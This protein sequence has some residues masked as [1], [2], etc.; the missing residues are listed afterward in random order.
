[1]S[2]TQTLK[3]RYEKL[4]GLRKAHLNRARQCSKLTIPHLLPDE[5]HD[6]NRELPTPYQGFGAK[7]VNNLSSKLW[8]TMLPPGS[9]F[10]KLSLSLEVKQEIEQQ[11]GDEYSEANIMSGLAT[12]EEAVMD[13]IENRGVRTP[14]FTALRQLVVTGNVCVYVPKKTESHHPWSFHGYGLKVFTLDQYVVVRDSM[15]N[16]V[17]LVI[18]E[19]ISYAA[20][21]ED[22]KNTLSDEV[23]KDK[24]E[25]DTVQLY[26]RVLRKDDDSSKFTVTQEVEDTPLEGM[27]GE[28]D[29]DKLPWIVLRWSQDSDYGRGPVEEYLGDLS[30]LESLSQALVEGSL[31]SAKVIFLCD[32]NGLTRPVDLATAKNMDFR[33]GREEDVKAL[34]IEKAND[35][36][37]AYQMIQEIERRLSEAFLMH[38]SVQR[39]AER[40]TAEEIRFLAQELED[41]LGGVYSLLSQ[42]FQLP[43]VTLVLNRL[44]GDKIPRLPKETINPVITTGL[45]ALGRN[46]EQQKL[47]HFLA[48]IASV[49][50]P[51]MASLYINPGEYIQRA[52]VNQGIKTEG[53][54]RSEEE[55]QQMLQ[56]QQQQEMAQNSAPQVAGK[57]TEGLMKQAE[58]GN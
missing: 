51:E 25:D 15:G 17:D 39:D 7:A 19:E 35:F 24:T 6:H 22:I 56:Q 30:T 36:A 13:Y 45:E 32:P 29:E 37:T 12:I 58:G 46:H 38:S 5:G 40:V 43:L 21:P 4:D 26:T 41:V 28:Y 20:L 23:R 53:L 34:R 10:F 42:E 14:T 31:G 48:D 8:L 33:Y 18:K 55:V 2:N 3:S 27:G 47:Q 57:V 9:T 44:Q 52:A 54:I 50:G 49:F 1:M 16:L 11:A